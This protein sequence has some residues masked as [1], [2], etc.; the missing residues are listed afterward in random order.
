M[1]G[2]SCPRFER[3]EGT[4][5]NASNTA[6]FGQELVDGPFSGVMRRVQADPTRSI[7]T[8]PIDSF[9][10]AHVPA[11]PRGKVA[12]PTKPRWV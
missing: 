11:R 3:Y 12:L 4:Q 10:G 1:P 8:I 5:C 6:K 9:T 2:F 7:D